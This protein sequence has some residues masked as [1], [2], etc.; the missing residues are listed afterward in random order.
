MVSSN[1]FP[2]FA[3]T[4]EEIPRFFAISAELTA[5]LFDFCYMSSLFSSLY[6]SFLKP[7]SFIYEGTLLFFIHLQ[8]TGASTPIYLANSA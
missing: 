2:A 7:F 3:I 8:T 6:Y 1:V 5:K 4:A